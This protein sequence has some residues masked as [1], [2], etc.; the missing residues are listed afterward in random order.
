MTADQGR[1][2][3]FGALG[4]FKLGAPLE[5]MSYKLAQ[6]LLVTFT[7][8]VVPIH[9][10]VTFLNSFDIR[11]KNSHNDT[12]EKAALKL[13][14]HTPIPYLLSTSL[15]SCKVPHW[16]FQTSSEKWVQAFCST[17]DT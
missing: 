2:F 10:H 1:I 13:Y 6:H 4:Y 16:Q 15:A 5:G 8:Q 7:G 3:I 17:H 12:N 9:K 14:D 11:N